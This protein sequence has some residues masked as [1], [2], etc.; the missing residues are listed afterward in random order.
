MGFYSCKSKVAMSRLFSH[1]C[2]CVCVPACPITQGQEEENVFP[3]VSAVMCV[4]TNVT[5]FAPFAVQ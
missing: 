2:V 1:V 4:L 5:V 3:G